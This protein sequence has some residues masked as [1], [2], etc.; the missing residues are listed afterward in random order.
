MIEFR[1]V[2]KYFPRSTEPAVN[3]LTL[4]IPKGQLTVLVGPSGCGKT[5]TMKMVNRICEVTEGTIYVDGNDIYKMDSIQLRL[6]IG[7]VIQEIGLFPHMTIKDNVAT[8]LYEKKWPKDKI[9]E[10]VDQLLNLMSLDPEVYKDRKPSSLSGGQRQRVGVARAMASNPPIMLM[11]EPFAAVDPITRERLQNEFL[12]LQNKMKK[13]IIFVTHDINEAIKMGDKIAV[14]KEGEIIQYDTPKK[15][16]QSPKTEFVRNLVGSNPSIKSLSLIKA[17]DI[18]F[19]IAPTIQF[20]NKVSEVKE[21]LENN[22]LNIAVVKEHEQV[23][24]F[25]SNLDVLNFENSAVEEIYRKYPCLIK[26][27]DSLSKVLSIMLDYNIY[28]VAV[29]DYQNKFSGVITIQDIFR[30]V[31]SN[32]S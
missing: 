9:N 12:E 30:A 28:H 32:E 22:D 25:I 15:L 21:K 5:T 7:Y 13:T 31:G 17:R 24:G 14:M 27:D 19:K 29:V 4:N 2:T 16:L 18:D 10:R 3:N 1:N 8:V 26:D 11:D 23:C 20:K 6:N